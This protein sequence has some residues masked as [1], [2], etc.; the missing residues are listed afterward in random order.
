M[1]WRD[2]RLSPEL[3]IPVSYSHVISSCRSWTN[4]STSVAGFLLT[5]SLYSSTPQ[6]YVNS[7]IEIWI[8]FHWFYLIPKSL[9]GEGERSPSSEIMDSLVCSLLIL[10]PCKLIPLEMSFHWPTTKY[11][12][13]WGQWLGL[14]DPEHRKHKEVAV[15]GCL[16]C[17]PPKPV[18]EPHH[19]FNLFWTNHPVSRNTWNIT[20]TNLPPQKCVHTHILKSCDAS[21]LCKPYCLLSSLKEVKIEL[22]HRIC[23]ITVSC[24]SRIWQSAL[25]THVYCSII[26]NSHALEI[27]H[28]LHK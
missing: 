17:T 24:L 15:W 3:H 13:F 12:G 19:T 20:H 10:G 14:S 23:D 8:F 21:G 4:S 27:V 6:C 26:Y 28:M 9:G 5:M 7:V 16:Q 25:H 22:L 2:L 1:C 18:P 11:T